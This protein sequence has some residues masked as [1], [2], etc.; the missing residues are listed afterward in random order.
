MMYKIVFRNLQTF[1]QYNQLQL[2]VQQL[3][4]SSHIFLLGYN[5]QV[6]ACSQIYYQIQG[7]LN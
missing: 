5:P 3:G 4:D 7:R 1:H 6:A 2:T